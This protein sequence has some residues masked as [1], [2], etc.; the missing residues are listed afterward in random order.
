MKK[1]IMVVGCQRSGTTVLFRSLAMDRQVKAFN[2]SS[3]NEIFDNFLL[4]PEFEIRHILKGID[5]DILLK[6]ISETKCRSLND[7]L[8]EYK[9]YDVWMVNRYRDPVNVYYSELKLWPEF[10]YP[11][12]F[13]LKWNNR[14][15]SFL[16][17]VSSYKIRLANVKYEDIVADPKVFIGLCRFLGVNG[18]YLFRRSGEGGRKFLSAEIKEKIDNGTMRILNE[19]DRNRTFIARGNKIGI[20]LLRGMLKVQAYLQLCVEIVKKFLFQPRRNSSCF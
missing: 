19:L 11:D 5:R 8:D 6:P 17:I 15:A 7:V 1:I 18:K 20:S 3:R 9:G 4:K 13:I 12:K 14:N 10:P 2:E 16:S